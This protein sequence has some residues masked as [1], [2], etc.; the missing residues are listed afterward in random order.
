MKNLITT[1]LLFFIINHPSFG[2][3]RPINYS[4]I[5]ELKKR[6]LIIE[7]IPL[8]PE[9]TENEKTNSEIKNFN[10]TLKSSIEKFWFSNAD[11]SVKSLEE[12]ESL[13]KK[14]NNKY[15]VIY[16]STYNRKYKPDIWSNDPSKGVEQDFLPENEIRVLNYSKIES[17]E[18][19][20]YSFYMPDLGKNI[21]K[22]P[23][24]SEVILSVKMMKNHIEESE[25]QQKKA[26]NFKSYS[27]DQAKLNCPNIDN[28]T[29]YINKDIA[30]KMTLTLTLKPLSESDYKEALKS[31]NVK[32]ISNAEINDKIKNEDDVLISIAIPDEVAVST[33]T[34]SLNRK[35]Y[36]RIFV[37]AKTGVIYSFAGATSSDNTQYFSTA[38]M[39]AIAK[40]K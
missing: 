29:L 6:P 23:T 22:L 14:G 26:Y 15:A 36:F 8:L 2:Q 34:Q 35:M 39:K 20:T 30:G 21:T 16:L 12:V 25:T 3:G 28:Q 32:I 31:D 13:R 40:C 1:F 5:S 10:E 17:G 38:D 4:E 24:E 27:K 7:S 33:T 11:I 18:K 37:N 9:S 19:P